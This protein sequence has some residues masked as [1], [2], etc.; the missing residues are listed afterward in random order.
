MALHVLFISLLAVFTAFYDKPFILS[1]KKK[2]ATD[3]VST[4]SFT[5][6]TIRP[7]LLFKSAAVILF[8]VSVEELVV[9]LSKNI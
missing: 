8:K 6:Q 7:E 1:K 2:T 5:L 3:F 9:E 4:F